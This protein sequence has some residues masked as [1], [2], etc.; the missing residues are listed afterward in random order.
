MAVNKLIKKFYP[1]AQLLGYT[2]VDGTLMFYNTVNKLI[3]ENALE[4]TLLDLGCGRGWYMY[5][6]K[7]SEG[8]LVKQLRNFKGKVKKVIGIDVDEKAATNPALDEF[9]LMEIDKP[10]PLEDASIDICICDYVMEH[11]SNVSFFFSELTR[12]I[13]KGGVVCFRTPNKLGYVAAISALI[14]NSLHTKVLKK[15]QTNRDEKDVFPVVYNCNTKKKFVAF[16]KEYGFDP[17]VYH[18]EA[19]PNYLKFSY[20]SFAFGYYLNK[21]LPK[22]LKNTLFSFGIK[23]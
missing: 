17:F 21:L 3:G 6:E 14:P 19:E 7:D 22:S 10:W 13:K 18:Y 9:R 11:V 15:V 12:V 23:R 4:K 16:F 1:E 8:Y 5:K 20:I 2:F